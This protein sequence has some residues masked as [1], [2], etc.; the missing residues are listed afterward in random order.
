MAEIK[1]NL[2]P[3]QIT[4]LDKAFKTLNRFNWVKALRV[5]GLVSSDEAEDLKTA[6]AS[7]AQQITEGNDGKE[8]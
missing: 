7:L 1:I 8:G 6:L 3:N 4:I 2:E 5:A